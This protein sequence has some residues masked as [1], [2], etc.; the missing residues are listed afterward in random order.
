[1]LTG[2]RVA[3]AG[4][5]VSGALAAIKIAAGLMGHSHAVV[6]DGL[7]SAGDVF[8]SGLVLLGLTLAAKPADWNHPYGHGRAE[9]VTGLFVGFSLA[10]TG[11]AIAVTA[12]R[13]VGEVTPPPAAFVV[14]PLIL[15]ALT[16][17]VL[18]G[19]KF[20]FGRKIRSAALMADAWNDSVDI[21]SA[22]A[23]LV[24]VSM[25][26][27]APHRFPS[28]D[29]WGAFAVGLIVIF[30]GLRVTRDITMQ[31]MDTMPDDDSVS[32]V[33]A[34]ARTVPGVRGVEKCY[35]RKTGLQYH[36][37]LHLEVDP[38]ITVRESHEIA[39]QVRIVIKETLPW[40]ADVLVHVEPA[41]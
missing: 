27:A 24:A 40:V 35:A 18:S 14:W 32:R 28:A 12:L 37:D 8:A 5:C 7:E 30:T 36:V 10:A 22:M 6:A 29:H 25:T 33:R 39:T 16:K 21:L 31:L 26:I 23:A 9:T 4:M 3:I 13:K 1:M 41:P 17:S 11:L 15:S 2:Q 20:H 19:V 34:A 38:E